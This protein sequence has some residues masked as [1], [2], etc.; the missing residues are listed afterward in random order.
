[1]QNKL[2]VICGPTAAGKTALAIVLAKKFNGEIVSA[3][4]RQVYRGMDIGTGKNLPVGVKIKYPWF[5]KIGFYEVDD[6]KIWGYDLAD[7]RE[8]FSVAR[9]VKFADKM[10]ADIEKRK[11]TPVLVGGTGLYIKGVVDR[12]PTAII[13][14]NES[15][16]EKLSEK[17]ADDLFEMLSQIDSIKA[18]SMNSSDKKN[19]RRLVRAIEVAT[20]MIDNRQK[21]VNADKKKSFDILFVGLTGTPGEIGRRIDESVASRSESGL[22]EEI[23]KLLR[24]GVK[25]DSQSMMSMGYRQ[26]RDFF[27]GGAPEDVV[28][29]EWAR[30]EKKYVK[31]QL[32]WFKKDKRINWFNIGSAGYRKKVENLVKKWYSSQ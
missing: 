15:L 3:D 27:E 32:T 8:D 12:I 31:R 25:W 30:E 21:I 7:P 28:L 1:M 26:Y 4:S 14:R 23:R 17:S 5:S 2:L 11:K 19:P 13:P 9:Y 18:G 22:R 24:M 6:V 20:W 29:E 10:I 16:R